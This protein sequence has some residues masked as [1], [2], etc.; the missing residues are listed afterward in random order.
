MYL[1]NGWRTRTSTTWTGSNA[2]WITTVL[3]ALV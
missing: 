3:A 1:L 2:E